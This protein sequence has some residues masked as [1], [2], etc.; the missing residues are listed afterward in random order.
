MRDQGISLLNI[1]GGEAYV[2]TENTAGIEGRQRSQA[3][4]MPV[5]APITYQTSA[6]PFMY[7]IGNP[8]ASIISGKR[9]SMP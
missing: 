9:K 5:A 2:V 1:V 8:L 4:I 7:Q 3:G 6:P